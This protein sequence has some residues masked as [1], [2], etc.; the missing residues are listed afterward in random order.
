MAEKPY[1]WK[2]GADLQEHSKAK[3]EI[4]EK[5][6]EKYIRERCKVPKWDKF[7]LAIVD[8]FAGGGVYNGGIPG[9][10]VILVNTLLKTVKQIN[11][12]RKV[13]DYDPVK[14]TCLMI[15]NDLDADAVQSLEGQMAP[16][17]AKSKES[18]SGVDLC[19]E[20]H[21]GKFEDKVREFIEKIAKEGY[22]S[23]LYFLDQC[24]YSKITISTIHNLMNTTTSVEVFLT[25]AIQSMLTYLQ[26]DNP[27]ALARSLMHLSIKPDD[28]LTI[29]SR[30][31]D[32]KSLGHVEKLVH[33]TFSGTSDYFSP[34]AINNPAGWKY[35]FMHFV[36]NVQGRVVFNDVL[37]SI[38]GAQAHFGRAGLNMFSYNPNDRHQGSLFEFNDFARDLSR[39]QLC[40][41]V[42]RFV[43]DYDDETVK[44]ERF[45]MDAFKATP[46]RSVDIKTALIN[47][48]DIN[49]ITENGGSR[50]THKGIHST[51]T[52]KMKPMAKYFIPNLTKG[53]IKK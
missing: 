16:C 35:W 21:N 48:P 46:A 27:E 32:E 3:H 30:I 31:C 52:I 15:M 17:E 4:Q 12:E 29:D 51:D 23:V 50:R 53:E 24:G 6:L 39:E 9:S 44:A 47:S 37:H 26:M 49:I 34:F 20:Y 42:V 36:K 1:N 13:K 2:E 25:Y 18:D 22:G 14:V 41:D 28:I 33:K 43:Y 45:I 19:T 7:K 40:E 38:D 10:P 8:G 11:L 5:Y